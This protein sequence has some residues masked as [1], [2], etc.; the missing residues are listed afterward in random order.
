MMH[1]FRTK[2]CVKRLLLVGVHLVIV[3]E[4]SVHDCVAPTFCPLTRAL[5]RQVVA[6]SQEYKLLCR[7]IER[8][9]TITY[10]QL[11]SGFEGRALYTPGMVTCVPCLCAMAI[12]FSQHAGEVMCAIIRHCQTVHLVHN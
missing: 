4:H 7:Y 5:Y 3:L 2:F 10:F 11:H 12:A 9:C 8:S 1:V 6:Y